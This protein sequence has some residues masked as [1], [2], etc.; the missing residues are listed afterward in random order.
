LRKTTARR[1]GVS[2]GVVVLL[3]GVAF[4]RARSASRPADDS[5]AAIPAPVASPPPPL[6][7]PPPDGARPPAAAPAAPLAAEALARFDE[8]HLMDRLRRAA[9]T[10]P[11][12]AIQLAREGKRRFPDSP[13][14]PERASI[15]IHT[16]A[17]Q[18]QS[19]EA[20]GEAEYMVNHYPDSSWVREIEQFTGAHRHRN[21]RVT[22]AGTIE[23]Q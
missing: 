17:N 9:G 4:W 12:L 16:L 19:R 13:D 6:A 14:A 21:I 15:L 10:D 18:G 8:A 20:R 11:A 23:Y 3:A 1:L 7:V 2:L 22:D 5:Q